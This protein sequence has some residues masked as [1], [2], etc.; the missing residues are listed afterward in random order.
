MIYK[1]AL[2]GLVFT[3]CGITV[4][5]CASLYDDDYSIGELDDYQIVEKGYDYEDELRDKTWFNPYTNDYDDPYGDAIDELPTSKVDD[6][7]LAADGKPTFSG[8]PGHCCYDQHPPA[9]R[10]T[11]PNTLL[12]ICRCNAM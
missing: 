9:H 7:Q 5:S 4:A 10:S 11:L 1:S 3:L 6:C 12:A 8:L 2:L